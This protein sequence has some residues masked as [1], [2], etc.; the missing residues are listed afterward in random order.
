[1]TGKIAFSGIIIAVEARI[2][3]VRSFDQI[4]THQYQG[5]TLI[6]DGDMG[7]EARAQF[8]V[9]VGPKAHEQHCFRIGDQIT[10][11]CR[12]ARVG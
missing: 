8:K 2:R 3:L 10:T 1:M 5:Y 6:V 4:P 11:E 9:A 7:G 12:A